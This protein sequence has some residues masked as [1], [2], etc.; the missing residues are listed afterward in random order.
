M[1]SQQPRGAVPTTKVP[2][3]IT[4]CPFN[5]QPKQHNA[6]LFSGSPA[7]SGPRKRGRGEDM[8]SSGQRKEPPEGYV[9]K[10]CQVA[11]H[12]IQDCP[13][14]AQQDSERTAKRE[15]VT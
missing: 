4:A 12:Y 2:D 11:G 8:S 15:K 7:G 1:A 5:K 10:I 9:C 3:G 14:K 6:F 13:T